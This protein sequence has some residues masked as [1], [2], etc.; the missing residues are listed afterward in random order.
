MDEV[1]MRQ[2]RGALELIRDAVDGAAVAIGR[3]HGDIAR[4]P[5]QILA[6][7]TPIAPAVRA[8]ENAQKQVTEGV[9]EAIRAINQVAATAA[10]SA[11]DILHSRSD[12]RVDDARTSVAI[13]H[14]GN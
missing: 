12:D 11:L 1:T 4:S 6:W 10:I 8:I 2:M 3:A 14:S 5:Y 7:L 13:R 9:Y